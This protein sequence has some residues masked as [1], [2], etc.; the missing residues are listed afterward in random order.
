MG[1]CVHVFASHVHAGCLCLSGR[2]FG[3]VHVRARQIKQ[4]AEDQVKAGGKRH[5]PAGACSDESRV[6]QLQR[7]MCVRA[8]HAGPAHM[9]R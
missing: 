7:S 5:H 1:A 3:C 2:A 6:W 9:H 4:E 8:A